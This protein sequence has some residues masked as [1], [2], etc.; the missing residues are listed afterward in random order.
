MAKFQKIYTLNG[1]VMKLISLF[2]LKQYNRNIKIHCIYLIDIKHIL[3]LHRVR[4]TQNH[5]IRTAIKTFGAWSL[6]HPYK[7]KFM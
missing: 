5:C 1:F 3:K 2:D 4:T 7:L 6:G